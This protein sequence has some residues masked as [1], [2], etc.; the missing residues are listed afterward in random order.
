MK[1]LKSILLASFIAFFST[2]C[3]TTYRIG[4]SDIAQFS[5]SATTWY[6]ITQ[7]GAIEANPLLSPW[8]GEPAGMAAL[9]VAKQGLAWVAKQP[10]IYPK[11][12]EFQ[13]CRQSS[14]VVFGLGSSAGI[15]NF[16]VI[17]FGS[18]LSWWAAPIMIATTAI[19]YVFLSENEC[20]PLLAA[21][22]TNK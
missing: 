17:L 13:G 19:H 3:A 20:A 21:A 5:D 9:I 8:I 14:A 11:G 4:P 22:A 16:G 15:N 7:A 10:G 2:S 6:A 12:Q 1:T 18:A